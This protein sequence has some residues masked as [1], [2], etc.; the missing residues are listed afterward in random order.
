MPPVLHLPLRAVVLTGLYLA[1]IE[2]ADRF[3]A[4]P[5]AVSLLWPASGLALAAVVRYGL[6]WVWFVPLALLIAH[7]TFSPAPAAFIPFSMASNLLGVLAAGWW[8]R[9]APAPE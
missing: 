3:I 8:I 6:R 4:A 9:G 2:F 5:G 7:N 1:A